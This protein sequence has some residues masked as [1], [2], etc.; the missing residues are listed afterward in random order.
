MS[1]AVER[2]PLRPSRLYALITR[3]LLPPHLT[4]DYGTQM[5]ETFALLRYDARTTAGMRGEAAVWWREMRQLWVV[6]RSEVSRPRSPRRVAGVAARVGGSG[7]GPLRG[8]VWAAN[9]RHGM[10]TLR[11]EPGFAVTVIV[12]LALG[13]GAN[14]TM[15]GVIDRL[16]LQA[17][18]HVVDPDSVVRIY[19]QRSFVDHVITTAGITYPDFTDFAAAEQFAATAAVGGREITV[20]HGADAIR[21]PGAM[22]S[23]SLFP[24]LGVQPAIGRFFTE[25][26]DVEGGAAV[27]VLGH[28]FWRRLGADPNVVGTELRLSGSLHTIVGVAPPGFTGVD[29][30]RVDIWVPLRSPVHAPASS[31]EQSRG[32]YWV[33]GIARLA[34]GAGIEAAAAEATAL[35]RAGRADDN[36]YDHEA[37]VVLGALVEARG[38]QRSDESVVARWLSGVSA[39]VLLVACANVAN[40]MLARGLRRR[41]ETG[42]RLALGVSRSRLMVQQLTDSVLLAAAGGLMALAVAY[43]GGLLVRSVLLPDIYWPHA[44]LDA[45]VMFFTFAAA[46]AAGVVAGIIPA[47]QATRQTVVNV[48]RGGARDGGQVNARARLSLV[49]GQAAVCVV[50]LVGAG[51]FVKSI[52]RVQAMDMGFDPDRLIVA[53][54]EFDED[55]LPAEEKAA[56]YDGILPRLR[57]LPAVA[58]AAASGALP[59]YWSLGT[60][61]TVPGREELPTFSDGGPYIYPVTGNYLETTG[62]GIRRGRGF[63]AADDAAA[64]RVVIIGE[65]M[66]AAYWPDEDPIGRCVHINKDEG[67]TQVIGIAEQANRGS[68]DDTTS[69]QYYV[70]LSQWSEAFSPGLVL[71]RA[72]PGQRLDALLPAVRREMQSA[73]AAVRFVSVQPFRELIDPQA[74]SWALGAT[75]FTAFG[76]LALAIASVGLYGVL[77][78][79][80]AQRRHEI[81][82]RSA[83]GASAG[84]LIAMV[85]GQA[86]RLVVAGL[87]LGIAFALAA[88]PY[89]E[90]MLFEVS[91]RDGGVLAVVAAVLALVGAVASIVPALRAARIEPLIALR[92]A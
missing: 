53:M 22:V 2:S 13:I 35:H 78:F 87:L 79:G 54:P 81:G 72:K 23:P 48:L 57:A 3:F 30:R 77:A 52:G 4:R 64:P 46:L 25:E 17:P 82:V 41:R 8:D 16:L 43:W 37:A 26:E 24:L 18:E 27:A 44:P 14:A 11:R 7:M 47:L 42:V 58:N 12:T 65:D 85:A 10:R 73:S 40:M 29:L 28:D 90:P 62:I 21:V 5:Q 15:F 84:G 61:F 68:L 31:W 91:G 36:Y 89:L 20:G 32:W 83:L 80:V 55:A 92:S 51:L 39:V 69:A 75:L 45:R 50:L 74:R 33:R 67:C 70:L 49:V 19:I 86:A 63:T 76:V 71:V 38:S 60:Y 1:A 88:G 9:L 66:A 34:E 6:G 56:Y 59:F